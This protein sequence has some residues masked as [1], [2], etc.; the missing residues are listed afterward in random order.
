[1]C[2][3]VLAA[4]VKLFLVTTCATT[5]T[6]TRA[7]DVTVGLL[8]L[9]ETGG[10]M[11]QLVASAVPTAAATATSYTTVVGLLR[12]SRD[13]GGRGVLVVVLIVLQVTRRRLLLRL[14]DRGRLLLLL[15]RLLLLAGR[16]RLLLLAG[17]MLLLQALVM[18]VM[19]EMLMVLRRLVTSRTDDRGDRLLL[20]LTAESPGSPSKRALLEHQ[21]RRRVHRP[22]VALAWAPQSLRQL[23]EALVQRQVMPN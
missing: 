15:L 16:M 18:V 19:M 21:L 5:R 8:A 11:V 17:R 20:A 2:Q 12:V 13:H 7:D 9:P 14:R 22:V 10:K 4:I 6:A 1:M 3:V 23:D